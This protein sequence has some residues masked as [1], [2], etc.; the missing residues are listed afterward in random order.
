MEEKLIYQQKG[1]D[2]AE[3]V[4]FIIKSSWKTNN[5]Y[6]A[7]LC[8]ESLSLKTCFNIWVTCEIWD[9]EAQL[10]TSR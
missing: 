2:V 9:Y 10:K 3:L 8:S 4:I 7:P 6:S 1:S 5:S